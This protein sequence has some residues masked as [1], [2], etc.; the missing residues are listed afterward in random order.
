MFKS[1]SLNF[2]GLFAVRTPVDLYHVSFNGDLPKILE[3]RLP[4]G[5]E[6]KT[7]KEKYPEPDVPRVSFGEHITGCIRAIYPNISHMVE[8]EGHKV[9]TMHVY[10]AVE[11]R[12]KRIFPPEILTQQKFVWDANLTREYWCLEPIEIEYVRKI[13]VHFD[14]QPPWT[15]VRPFGKGELKE[16]SPSGIVIKELAKER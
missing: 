4:D 14:T 9:L 7:G 3:P 2:A 10:R 16:H 6:L 5:T 15:K 11:P 8:E 1:L 12:E 13:E